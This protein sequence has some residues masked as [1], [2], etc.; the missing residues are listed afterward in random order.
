MKRDWK[1]SSFDLFSLD[2]V[3]KSAWI[4][5]VAPDAVRMRKALEQLAALYPHL[6]GRYEEKTK[7]LVW[8]D[9]AVVE[10][11]F[12]TV[13][14]KSYTVA[15]LKGNEKVWSLVKAYSTQ[16]F[17]K[18]KIGPFQ[19]VLAYLKD[20]AV[21]YVQC[22]HA[23]MDGTTFYKLIGQWVSLYQGEPATPMIVDQSQI[24]SPDA[25][26]K[27][28]TVRQAKAKGWVAMTPK[29]L[30]KM[31]WNLFR[32]SRIKEPYILEVDQDEILQVKEEAGVGTNAALTAIMLKAFSA[33]QSQSK[34][35]K[36]LFVADLR[37]RFSGIAE[38]FFGNLSQPVV[39]EG[40]FDPAEKTSILASKIDRALKASLASGQP[41]E[42][43][44]LSLSCSHYSLPYVYFDPSD[45]NCANPGTVY[46]NNQLKFK[47]CELDW[48]TGKPV[49]VFPNDL[50]DMVKFW[51]PATDFPV[52]V[53]FGGMAAKAMKQ[54]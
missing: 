40:E 53:I 29:K 1:L 2:M 5:P 17:K 48:G 52:Q 28:E 8:D 39:A 6:G 15:A 10:L 7:S 21:L 13:D 30:V 36:L 14:L 35:Y 24:P 9:T 51:Q 16:D 3:I 54:R 12:T 26:S 34:S 49:Y 19:A 32:N 33:C 41:E 31:L 20:G 18:G 45:M 11:P 23:T 50:P 46:V 25:L 44:R 42:H 22:A 27:D 47:A 4:Y 38:S 37:G 43:V